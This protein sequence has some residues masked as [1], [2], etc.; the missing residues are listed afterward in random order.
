MNLKPIINEMRV[1]WLEGQ[2]GGQT[3]LGGYEAHYNRSKT[4]LVIIDAV[5]IVA[6]RNIPTPIYLWEIQAE[7]RSTHAWN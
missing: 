5:T 6:H 2:T 3:L 4:P 1:Y 7:E